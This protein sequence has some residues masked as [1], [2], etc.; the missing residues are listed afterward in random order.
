MQSFFWQ[1]AFAPLRGVAVGFS[2]ARLRRYMWRGMLVNLAL[3]I[4]LGTLLIMGGRWLGEVAAARGWLPPSLA[5]LGWALAIVVALLTT[6]VL[7]ALTA[8]IAR[9]LIN[10]KVYARARALGGQPL[11]HDPSLKDDVA[12][13]WTDVRRLVRFVGQSA[14][15]LPLH[16]VPGIGSGLYLLL[17]ALL[18]AHTMGWDLLAFHFEQH[19]LALPAQRQ[20]VRRN[21]NVV[22]ALGTG[23]LMLSL[24]PLLQLVFLQTNIVGAGLLSAAIDAADQPAARTTGDGTTRPAATA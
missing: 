7:V 8:E 18:S 23:A 16:L 17:Q 2:D 10:G 6:P 21:R 24:V 9:P 15:L 22:L 4:A 11:L 1:A 12:S 13:A 5:W 3:A 20:W 14:L 19:R